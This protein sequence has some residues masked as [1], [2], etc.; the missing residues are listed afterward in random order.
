[1]E[2]EARVEQ[3]SATIRELRQNAR[4][5]RTTRQ[6]LDS[7]FRT[8]HSLKAAASAEGLNDLSRIAHEFEDLLHALRTGKL[9][10][11]DQVLR[12]FDDTTAALLGGAET[13]SLHR[14]H[15]LTSNTPETHDLLPAEF[16]ALK[17]HERHRAA[18]AMRE[19]AN[20]YVM[21][22]AFDASN[23]DQQFRY[24]KA[25]LDQTGEVISTAARAEGDLAD[26][27]RF[28]FLYAAKSEKI[29]AETIFQQATRAGQSTAEKLA[30]EV[31]F[32]VE[33]GDVLL[34]RSV[35][36][37]LAD[38]LLH[39]VR[40]AVDHGIDAR[41]TITLNAT[42]TRDH[43]RITVIDDGRGIDPANLPLIFQPGF[44][45]AT[46]VTELSGRGV[47][48]DAVKAAVEQSGGTVT[49]TSYPGSGSSFEIMLPNPSSDA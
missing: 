38:S 10:L 1:M 17:D 34:E 33:G 45:T 21:E 48:L 7:L 2:L 14:L 6:L 39:L 28:Q 42:T 15:E 5:G 3:I 32:V 12:A 27:I 25:Q 9:T 44:S 23:F 35:S 40:N 4:D 30:K 13:S 36:D 20:L 43:T 47:G 19:G 37:T 31:N 22:V 46:E 26:K 41:G 18:E 8:V 16:T 49:V 11:D 24:L 29:P